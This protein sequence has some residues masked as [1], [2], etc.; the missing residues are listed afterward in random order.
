V[1]KQG[2]IVR[3]GKLGNFQVGLS[4]DGFDTKEEVTY[5]AVKKR[6]FYLDLLKKCGPC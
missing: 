4:S 6:E 5:S 2:R 3:L 1:L